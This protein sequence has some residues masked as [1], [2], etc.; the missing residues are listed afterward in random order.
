MCCSRSW[1]IISN[2]GWLC[3][4][5]KVG[6]IYTLLTFHLVYK[7]DENCSSLYTQMV[8]VYTQC[9]PLRSPVFARQLPWFLLS[10]GSILYCLQ[11][12]SNQELFLYV[13]RDK[14]SVMLIAP[15]VLYH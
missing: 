4:I 15:Y 7:S 14:A 5:G 6:C 13:G 8:L 2:S 10:D 12:S 1:K 9:C 11:W 3:L